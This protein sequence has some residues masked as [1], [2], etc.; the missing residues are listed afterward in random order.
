MKNSLKK[1]FIGIIVIFVVVSVSLTINDGLK[2]SGNS[3]NIKVSKVPSD[4]NSINITPKMLKKFPHIVLVYYFHT[5]YRCYSCLKIEELTNKAVLTGFDKNIKKGNL[6]FTGINV[7]KPENNHFITDYKLFTKS[8]I[9]V[10]IKNGK[11]T[12]WKNLQKVWELIG[13]EKAFIDYVQNE[14]NLYLEGE[15]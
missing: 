14:V 3:Q 8:V 13:N 2:N 9:V 11:E 4:D 5:T 1:I 12:K 10:D 7:D 15:S 6:I